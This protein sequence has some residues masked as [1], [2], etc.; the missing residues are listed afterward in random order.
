MVIYSEISSTLK[1]VD[2]ICQSWHENLVE[3][4]MRELIKNNSLRKK[5]LIGRKFYA[6]WNNSFGQEF[7][8]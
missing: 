7:T 6:E 8:N 1:N 2:S 5:N 3:F 4:G